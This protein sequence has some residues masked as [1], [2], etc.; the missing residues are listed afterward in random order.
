[1][2][3]G[4]PLG[5]VL[6]DLANSVSTIIDNAAASFQ[7]AVVAAAG[8]VQDAINNAESA[9]ANDLNTAINNISAAERS[10]VD[11]IQAL[12]SNLQSDA[13]QLAQTITAD[14]QQ[15]INTLPFT[16]KNPQV[17]SYTPQFTA[18]AAPGSPVQVTVNG[19]FAWAFE[20]QLSPTVRVGGQA[21]TADEVTTQQLGFS[22]PGSTFTGS[23]NSLTPVSLELDVP[24]ES[25]V[26]FKTVKPG[27][28]YLLVTVLP[29]SPVTTLT[30]TTAVSHS[31]TATKPV[32]DPPNASAAGGGIHLDSFDCQDHKLTGTVSADPGWSIVPSSAQ[33]HYL[34][35]KSPNAAD[36]TL[37][38]A[39]SVIT[40]TATTKA[41]CF[42]GVS[43]GSGDI[44]FYVSFTEEQ[45]VTTTTPVTKNLALGWGDQ[46]VEPVD[47]HNWSLSATLFSGATVQ[48]DTTSNSNEYLS[49]VDEGSSIQISAPGT[50]SLGA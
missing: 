50:S 26:I 18:G 12:V 20:K 27:T 7:A 35:N 45:S 9:F 28:F 39:A 23:H 49:V 16:N 29:P 36:V 22:L 30:L 5:L 25:G 44:T 6:D 8:Q 40:Y 1:V 4:D 42:L 11:Q 15:L 47:P 41:N 31:G 33:V 46:L 48:F 10:A 14:A 24:Y 43:D 38:V 32:T 17:T 3:A 2:S 37:D 13:A 21:Y 19:N 34:E